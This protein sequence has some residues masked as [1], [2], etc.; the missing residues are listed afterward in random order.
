MAYTAKEAKKTLFRYLNITEQGIKFIANT[1]K[2][3]FIYNTASGERCVIFIYPIS[4]KADNSKNFFDTRDSG[5]YER[6]VSWNYALE[7]KLKYFCFAVHDQVEKY[8]NY[9]FSLE[10]QEKIIE[11]VSGTLNGARVGTGTQVVIPNDYIP[12]NEFE[13]ILTKKGFFIAVIHKD[14][15]IDYIE[16]RKSVV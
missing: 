5:A 8:N 7:N 2:R 10:C 15:I 16:D 6:G 11:K 13:R 4:H 12:N 3:G 9:I 1:H 14:N